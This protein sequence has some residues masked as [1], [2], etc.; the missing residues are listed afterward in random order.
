MSD[1]PYVEN[2]CLV[3]TPTWALKQDPLILRQ[4]IQVHT[5]RDGPLVIHV[6]SVLNVNCILTLSISN[7]LYLD[8]LSHLCIHELSSSIGSKV[9]DHLNGRF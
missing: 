9:S 8:L 5:D 6:C 4:F 3:T 2:L 7:V 1:T